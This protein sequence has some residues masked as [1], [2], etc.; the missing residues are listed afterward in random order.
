MAPPS[1]SRSDSSSAILQTSAGHSADA[2]S[3]VPMPNGVHKP[4][5]SRVRPEI[6]SITPR[7]I[8]LAYALRRR[9]GWALGAGLVCAVATVAVAWLAI[10][11]NYTAK[12]WLRIAEDK[13]KIMFDT[14]SGDEFLTK[15]QAQATLMTSNFVLNAALRKPGVSQLEYLREEIDP[16]TWLQKNI[17]V[18]FP[19]NS[20]ILQISMTGDDPVQ[21]VKLVNAVKDA[22]MEEVV[23][24][25]RE[26][27][28]RRKSVLEQSYHRNTEEIKRKAYV[29][30]DLADELGT[31]VD[32]QFTAGL[33]ERELHILV[34]LRI[35]QNKTQAEL[36][37]WE[38]RV[39]VLEERLVLEERPDRAGS[40][41]PS[42]TP[43]DQGAAAK[44]GKDA[45]PKPSPSASP[46]SSARHVQL[47]DAL[48]AAELERA[49]LAGSLEITGAEIQTVQEK[50]DKPGIESTDL[51][52]KRAELA[53]LRKITANMGEA[54]E[55]WEIELAAAP[56]VSLLEAAT[57]PKSNDLHLKVRKVIAAACAALIV[58]FLVGAA[59]GLLVR[60]A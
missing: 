28:H 5:P 21:L 43:G 48:E 58:G 9:W 33:L 26:A 42:E 7:P 13:P 44:P 38:E 15:R 12:A 57:V 20:E 27:H 41:S 32:P 36:A 51:K 22:Y 6:L 37:G 11:V 49:A 29:F 40:P 19:G 35:Q 55:A 18:A 10:P 54:L 23:S 53:R 60:R 46:S 1:D 50:V 31:D 25:D 56:R 24:V 39:R 14:G 47:R 16:V 4:E 3:L 59:S 52:A 2:G 30:K 34:Q 8:D 45:S 17:R